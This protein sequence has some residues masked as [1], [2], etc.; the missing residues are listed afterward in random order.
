M[1]C[2]LNREQMTNR[3]GVIV[4]LAGLLAGCLDGNGANVG[5]VKGA[6]GDTPI[7]Y[8]ICGAGEKAC[9]LAARFAN[10]DGCE[11]HKKWADMLCDSSTPGVMNC[12]HNPDPIGVAYCTQ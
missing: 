4:A 10:L 2:N 6:K 12:R 1:V 7:R 8:V 11:S 9:F 5:G 3:I